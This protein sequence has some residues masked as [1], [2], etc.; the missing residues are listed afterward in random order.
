[1]NSYTGVRCRKGTAVARGWGLN[2]KTT[3][4]S[5]TVRQ[6]WRAVVLI[7]DTI[8]SRTKTQYLSRKLRHVVIVYTTVHVVSLFDL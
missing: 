5:D 2:F 3:H 8:G 1:M 4:F 6:T 7:M